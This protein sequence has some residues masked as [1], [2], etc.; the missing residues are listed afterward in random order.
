MAMHY[1]PLANGAYRV[2]DPPQPFPPSRPG[3]EQSP[4]LAPG[5]LYW[6]G[7]QR[8]AA[9]P[10]F[11]QSPQ[12][13]QQPAPAPQ[14]PQQAPQLPQQP[15]SD[16]MGAF[17]APLDEPT[18]PPGRSRWPLALGVTAGVVVLSAAAFALA[19]GDKFS[20]ADTFAS[21]GTLTISS[22]A[23]LGGSSDC[24]LTPDLE[25][26]ATSR[27][28][29]QAGDPLTQVAEAPIQYQDGTLGECTFTFA[30]GDV[31]AGQS[32]YLV[33]LPGHGELNYTEQEMRD[34]VDIIIER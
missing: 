8:P 25:D 31:P 3:P 11:A 5:G 10:Q 9:P 23:V 13:Q 28:T 15:P 6:D 33:S 27:L 14:V 19:P 34:G 21:R 7:M 2:G 18:R 30:L 4:R 12:F 16:V 32:G 1:P 24:I 22:P 20:G 26:I 17:G 29:V